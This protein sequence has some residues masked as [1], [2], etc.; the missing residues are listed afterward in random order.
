LLNSRQR[1]RVFWGLASFEALAV[2]RDALFHSYM[3]IYLRGRLG[4]SMTETTLCATLPML[5]NVVFQTMLWGRVSDRLQKRRT[6]IVCGEALAGVGTILMF[7]A[8]TVP[9]STTAKGYAIILGLTVIEAFWSMSNVGRSALFADIY[10]EEERGSVMGRLVGLTGV[11]WLVGNAAGGMFYDL[12]GKRAAGWGFETGVLFYITSGVMFLSIF[13]MLMVPEGGANRGPRADVK[14]APATTSGGARLFVAFLIGMVFI[15]WGRNSIDMIRATYLDVGEGFNVSPLELSWILNMESA[16]YIVMGLCAGYYSRKIDAGRMLLQGA[17]ISVLALTLYVFATEIYFIYVSNFLRG[18]A[19]AIIAVSSYAFV[20]TLIPPE[21]RGRLFSWFN[22]T[23]HLSWGVAGTVIAG[24]IV[25]C[26]TRI[27]WGE[28]AAYQASFGAAA[29][30][31]GTGLVIMCYVV[32]RMYPEYR[33][34]N[35]VREEA[36]PLRITE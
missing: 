21:K 35:P 12:F 24:P 18:C 19:T 4:M 29:G 1:K 11:G 13:P 7:F 8:H 16:A 33:R 28:V 6:L 34:R 10:S 20:S 30:I 31:T 9:E 23:Y 5:A 22:A 27:G 25:D 17:A 14:T 26:L 32:F 3:A 36:A 2:F 15:L